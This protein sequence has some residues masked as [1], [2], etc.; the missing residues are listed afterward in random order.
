M[1][2]CQA[3]DGAEEMPGQG[4]RWSGPASGPR[5]RILTLGPPGQSPGVSGRCRCVPWCLGAAAVE[6]AQ[7][8]ETLAAARQ[9]GEALASAPCLGSLAGA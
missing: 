1:P 9:P 5:P 2:G 7:P 6:W 8:R 3:C 4:A